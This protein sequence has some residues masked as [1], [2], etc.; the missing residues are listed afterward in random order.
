MLKNYSDVISCIIQDVK[1]NTKMRVFNKVEKYF[2]GKHFTAIHNWPT[3]FEN[4]TF[5]QTS[6]IAVSL[7]RYRNKGT[8]A[9]PIFL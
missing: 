1:K 5:K 2:M 7:T 9:S 6:T 3:E 8:T 4:K